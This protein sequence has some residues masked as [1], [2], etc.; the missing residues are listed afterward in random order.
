MTDATD[1]PATSTALAELLEIAG[2]RWTLRILWELR[3]GALAFNELRA[4]A[5]GLSQSVLVTRLTELFGAGLVGDVAGGYEL[6]AHGVSLVRELT[7]LEAWCEE[8]ARD[9]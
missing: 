7:G 5:G 3:D 4:R 8:W 6:T 2:R 9:R 1:R